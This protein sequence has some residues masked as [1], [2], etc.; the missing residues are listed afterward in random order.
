MPF[1]RLISLLIE[2]KV[3]Y[4][5]SAISYQ[6][7]PGGMLRTRSYLQTERAKDSIFTLWFN[8]NVIKH[9]HHE[10]QVQKFHDR[11]ELASLLRGKGSRLRGL[12]LSTPSSKD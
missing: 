8:L 3:A 5:I 7:S 10:E 2:F 11:L 9:R 12:N 6:N 4:G 1:G